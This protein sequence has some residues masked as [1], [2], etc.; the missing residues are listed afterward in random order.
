MS[1][2]EIV[3]LFS[4]HETHLINN[5][6]ELFGKSRC[7]HWILRMDFVLQPHFYL[8]CFGRPSRLFNNLVNWA[9]D[10]L[11]VCVHHAICLKFCFFEVFYVF[12]KYS[13]WRFLIIHCRIVK[14]FSYC[15]WIIISTLNYEFCIAKYMLLAFNR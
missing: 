12:E 15:L 14:Y 9:C 1:N 10:Y 2:Y 7:F 3:L 11:E 6:L 4:K 5:L 8:F 13:T